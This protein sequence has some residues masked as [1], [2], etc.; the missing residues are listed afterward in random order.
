LH[1]IESNEEPAQE[2]P[3][4]APVQEK[5]QEEAKEE[6]EAPEPTAVAEEQKNEESKEEPKAVQPEP[7]IVVPPRPSSGRFM[8]VVHPS[9][10]MR[11]KAPSP[12]API[13]APS[14]Q[15]PTAPPVVNETKTL[16]KE[17]ELAADEAPLTPFL[18]DAN[19]K[20]KK[21]PLG[22]KSWP[23]SR[24]SSD[25]DKEL[26][27]V[28]DMSSA[29]PS[30]EEEEPEVKEI[31]PINAEY[32]KDA[33]VDKE[34]EKGQDQRLLDPTEF[35]ELT[36]EEKALQSIES[37]E[38]KESTPDPDV[39]VRSVESGDTEHLRVDSVQE[40]AG[41][42]EKTGGIYDT[43]AYHQPIGQPKQKSGWGTV[44]IIILVIAVCIGSAIA[45]FLFLGGF[46]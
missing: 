45:A 23:F 39:S 30:E 18:P 25:A 14:P 32:S 28:E 34:E 43:Q 11:S 7:R 41:D 26:E 33:K 3:K 44:V 24:H 12:Y 38:I 6:V 20:V 27:K 16:E 21:R 31:N 19:E 1:E 42:A 13:G 46:K 9:A 2:Q 35:E 15:V 17:L 4:E 37:A 5:L 29:V 10:D 22:A 36:E 8:D 40:A